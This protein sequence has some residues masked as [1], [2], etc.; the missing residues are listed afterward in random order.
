MAWHMETARNSKESA[1]P[2]TPERVVAEYAP[3]REKSGDAYALVQHQITDFAKY[4][5]S[6]GD[7]PDAEAQERIDTYR[8]ALVNKIGF[9]ISHGYL[10]PKYFNETSFEEFAASADDRDTLLA[11]ASETYLSKSLNLYKN[12]GPDP[13][14]TLAEDLPAHITLSQELSTRDRAVKRQFDEVIAENFEAM[15]KRMEG[16]A[17]KFGKKTVELFFNSGEIEIPPTRVM[18]MVDTVDSYVK[19]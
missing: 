14:V 15:K 4:K 3:L 7:M 12:F 5:E 10:Y 18:P 17:R 1:V 6:F 9:N 13:T 19:R 8:A 2:L 11:I 16:L